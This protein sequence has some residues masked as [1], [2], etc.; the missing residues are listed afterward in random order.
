L[1]FT[2]AP[3]DYM[4]DHEQTSYL[5]RSACFGYG[6]PN[7]S[8]VPLRPGT[9][10]PHLYYCDT[11]DGRGPMGEPVIPTTRIDISDVLEE[12]LSVLACHESQR[13][14]LRS[15]HGMDEYLDSVRRRAAVRGL[16][17][18]VASAEV[19]VQHRGHAYPMDDLLVTWL[20]S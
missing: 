16:E 12:K 11:I 1:V 2:H 18:G 14:W 3:R 9:K 17:S 7:V 4:C 5:A 13:E 6:T 15:Y 10:V 20:S 8:Y 19:F